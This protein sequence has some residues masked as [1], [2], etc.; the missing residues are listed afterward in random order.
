MKNIKVPNLKK[1]KKA[2]KSLSNRISKN[3]SSDFFLDIEYS[4]IGKKELRLIKSALGLNYSKKA[5]RN[6]YN[7]RDYKN[8]EKTKE[9][10]LLDTMVE[11]GFAIRKCVKE[12]S[13][14][15]DLYYY[16]SEKTISFLIQKNIIK[17]DLSP[18]DYMRKNEI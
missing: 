2:Q 12:N 13:D 1:L 3:P 5:Y 18:R 8:T 9:K 7:L 10:V 16:F 17:T 4:S 11:N 6:Y 15:F 14:Y